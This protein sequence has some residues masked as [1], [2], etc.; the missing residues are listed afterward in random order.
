MVAAAWTNGGM[1][2]AR[3]DE[4]IT[5]Q[6]HAWDVPGCAVAA[7]RD[8]QAVL[9]RGYGHR[10]AEAGL[11]V[12]PGTLFAIGSLT[13][14]FTA[15]A[16]G[17]LVDDGLLEWDRPLRDY[18]TDIRLHDPVATER[19][20][21]TDLLA[22]RSGLPRHDLTWLGQPGR[23]RADLVRR[24]RFLPLSRDLR[25]QYQY[26]NLGYLAAGHV[27]D[28][29]SGVTWEKFTEGRLLGPLGMDRSNL[30]VD[31]MAADPDH[32]TG[33]ARRADVT[34][35]VP[36]RPI[37]GPAPAGAINSCAADLTRWLLA[38]LGGGR[39]GG[40]EVI[41]PATL[42]RQHQP[43]MVAEFPGL[44][45]LAP[46]AYGLGWAI[47]RYAGRR[48]VLHSGG[49]DGFQ[50]F[51]V[52]L[53]DD[54]AGVAVL[55]NASV[56]MMP[57]IAA[58]RVLDELAGTEPADLFS[59]LKPRHDAALVGSRA[60]RAARR[61]VPGAEPP[62]PLADYAGDYE[63]PGYGVL[64][65]AAEG[66]TLRPSFGTMK[67]S[68]AHRHY[69]IF[70]L[71]WHELGEQPHL[72][73][74]TFLPDP[75]GDITALTVPFE[76]S[77]EPLRFTR[78][79]EPPDAAVLEEL[80]GTYAMGPVTAVIARKGDQALT[81]AVAGAPTLD[82]EPLRGLRFRVVG[83]PGTAE[84]ELDDSGAVARLVAQPIGVF[85]PAPRS[86]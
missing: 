65:I 43:H 28:V 10:D 73:P 75:D 13:K 63:H 81:A 66:D 3:V 23:S 25:Q 18:G 50:S 64:S 9:A 42:K 41:S 72:Y 82:L 38:Q 2:S 27:V 58:C 21:I 84:F 31:D 26:C 35:P 34:G 45:S 80:C 52:L 8:G 86:D 19:L 62:R 24:L 32:A 20:T 76:P 69:E 68:L 33:Y 85:T 55:T 30:S 12:T 57:L 17:A 36:L 83:Q 67:L 53:P 48:A 37:T 14:S 49:I 1:D 78:R 6:L 77:V 40:K 47:G 11:P 59:V 54:G 15:S 39:D 56:S 22:H 70:D 61:V 46:Y 71:T 60:A 7:V 29:L 74:L 44:S 79:P 16:I 5:S 4:F 51:C